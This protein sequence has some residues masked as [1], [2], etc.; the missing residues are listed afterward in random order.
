MSVVVA[1]HTAGAGI[2]TMPEK[3]RLGCSALTPIAS[4]IHKKRGS[5]HF[6]NDPPADSEKR[7]AKAIQLYVADPE[8][9]TVGGVAGKP[10]TQ[11]RIAFDE[12]KVVVLLESAP[13]R[14]GGD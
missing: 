2:N 14:P 13:L 4:A 12:G 10:E 9:V 1:H 6:W 11:S 7:L 8:D 3:Y 5:F